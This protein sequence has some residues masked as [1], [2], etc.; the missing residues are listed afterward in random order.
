MAHA[1]ESCSS[2][3]RMMAAVPVTPITTGGTS[4]TSPFTPLGERQEA[5]SLHENGVTTLAGEL[6]R[7]RSDGTSV[8]DRGARMSPGLCREAHVGDPGALDLSGIKPAAQLP[9]AD[10]SSVRP[11]EVQ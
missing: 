1:F 2:T 11:D 9:V 6:V 7:L 8:V 3:Q 5:G 10:P 4:A